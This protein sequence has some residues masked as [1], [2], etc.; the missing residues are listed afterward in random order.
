[1][2]LCVTGGAGYIGSVVVERLLELG[3]D[4]TVLDN[5][6]TGHRSAVPAECRF[7]EGDIRDRDALDRAIDSGTDAVLHFAA[8]SL[9]GESVE[10]PL[11]YFD[12][13]VGGTIRLLEAVRDHG[14]DRFVFSSSAAVYG[15]PE[16]L[17]IDE[18]APCRPENPYGMTKLMIER[19]LESSSDAFGL[20]FVALR[21]FNAGGSTATRGEDHDPET[22]LIPIVLDVALG[23]RDRLTIFGS[24]YDTPDGTCIRDY[25]HVVDL[26]EAHVLALEAMDRGFCGSL[27]LG[28]EDGFTVRQVVERTE[29]VTGL[30]V[31]HTVG[32]RRPGDPPALVASSR[33]AQ[34][35]L[36]W[37]Q[38]HSGLDEIIR[39]A[40][41]WRR[42]HPDGYG[43]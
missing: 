7:V 5:L 10:K 23:R 26:A 9:V 25:I 40:W 20:R 30:E 13:N 4:I 21:Y 28:S 41:E 24:D 14:V 22:H 8:L 39:S 12:N 19:V 6:R 29:A 42:A 2:K 17:P 33:L 27:N 1:M 43:D 3:H 16:S 35:T 36:R 31:A 37:K 18:T 11:A 34:E 38:R 15:A 32:E